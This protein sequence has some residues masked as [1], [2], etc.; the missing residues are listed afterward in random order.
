MK[1]KWNPIQSFYHKIQKDTYTLRQK[2]PELTLQSPRN[3][4]HRSSEHVA[5]RSDKIISK[6]KRTLFHA[7]LQ[8]ALFNP[9]RVSLPFHV[10][11]RRGLI[12]NCWWFQFWVVGTEMRQLLPRWGILGK[13]VTRRRGKSWVGLDDLKTSDSIGLSLRVC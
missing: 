7:L 10:G 6:P 13:V 1:Y 11:A 5:L 12:E 4:N 2:L 3:R 9:C 8:I